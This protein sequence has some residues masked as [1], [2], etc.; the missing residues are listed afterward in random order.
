MFFSKTYNICRTIAKVIRKN[1]LYLFS[2]LFLI[3]V[4]NYGISVLENSNLFD[5]NYHDKTIENLIYEI[6]INNKMLDI[7]S[8]RLSYKRLIKEEALNYNTDLTNNELNEVS[9]LIVD[10]SQKYDNITPDF[11]CSVITVE[12]GWKKEAKSI[13]NANGMMQIV[14]T[15]GAY[16]SFVEGNYDVDIYD[17]LKNPIE[18]IKLGC[19][20]LYELGGIHDSYSLIKYN[21]GIKYALLYHKTKDENS[22]PEE[23]QNYIINVNRIYNENKSKLNGYL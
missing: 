22:L 15:T 20:Y 2:C 3:Y 14:P 21:A 9:T 13:A 16:L 4:S 8:Q 1:I 6:E 19:R 7:T 11:I 5:S 10:L 17:L 23:T 18:N 12:S